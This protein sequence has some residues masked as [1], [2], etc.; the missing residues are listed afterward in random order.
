MFVGHYAA[1]LAAKAAEP[2]APLWTYMAAAQLI[3]IGWSS[4]IMTGVEH[5]RIDPSLPGSALVLYDMPWTHSLPAALIWSVVAGF[6]AMASL[7]LPARAAAMVGAVVFSHWL[8][9][10]WVHRPD[11]LIWFGGPKMGFALW[12]DPVPEMIVEMGLLA[13]AGALWIGQRKDEGRH[14]WTGAVYIAALAILQYVSATLHGGGPPEGFARTALI[15][16]LAV[17]LGAW[18]LDRKPAPG[19]RG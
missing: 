15:A 18:W 19:A 17:T 13:V 6:A 1:A 9:D 8:G 14:A 10:L 3:D 7:K 5:L 4:F 12:N 16:Y 2:R 11:L